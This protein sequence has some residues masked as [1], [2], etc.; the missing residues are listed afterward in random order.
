MVY[1]PPC[2][3]LHPLSKDISINFIFCLPKI[4]RRFHSTFVVV[5]RFSKMT[6]FIPYHMVEPLD[7][8]TNPF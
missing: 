3:L 6:H 1:T 4:Q 8:R 2:M 7:L 5:D